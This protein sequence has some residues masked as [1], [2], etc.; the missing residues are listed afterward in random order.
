MTQ[1]Q[2]RQ[3]VRGAAFLAFGLFYAGYALLKLD[4]GTPRAMG[5]GMFP[6]VIGSVVTLF[7]AGFAAPTLLELFGGR[8][9]KG[10]QAKSDA[11]RWEEIEWRGILTVVA[12]IAVFAALVGRFGL[13]PATFAMTA[14]AAVG[15]RKLTPFLVVALS[16]LFLVSTW[17]IF[18]LGLNLPLVMW[19]WPF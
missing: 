8:V 14:V 12:S 17:V 6:L 9:A 16:I 1:A 7:G 5:A 4:I 3:L 19:D 15:N 13:I 18:I 2:Q 11:W 10:D